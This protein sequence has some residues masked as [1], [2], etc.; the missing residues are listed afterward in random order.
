MRDSICRLMRDG[1]SKK[2]ACIRST[3]HY[4][5]VQQSCEETTLGFCTRRSL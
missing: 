5:L 2:L 1:E 3:G 4:M